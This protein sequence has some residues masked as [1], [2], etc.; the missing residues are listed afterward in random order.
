MSEPDLSNYSAESL[1]D[2]NVDAVTLGRLASTRP[3]LWSAILA[4]PNVYP[5]LAQ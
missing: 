4:H 3:D 5:D 2:P 1:A